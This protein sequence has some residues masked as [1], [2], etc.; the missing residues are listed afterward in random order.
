MDEKT[1]RESCVHTAILRADAILKIENGR[2]TA[3]FLRT[4]I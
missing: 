4:E 1:F 3:E 2:I